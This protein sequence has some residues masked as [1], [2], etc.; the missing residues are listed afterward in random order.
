MIDAKIKVDGVSY[1]GTMTRTKED[2]I[3]A[4]G[5]YIEQALQDCE[6]KVTIEFKEI[7]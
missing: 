4:L 6:K 5:L 2:C 7:E 1:V 3:K